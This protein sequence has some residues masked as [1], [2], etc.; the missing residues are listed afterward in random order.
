[1]YSPRLFTLLFQFLQGYIRH[2]H[3][4]SQFWIN[5]SCLFIPWN[6]PPYWASILHQSGAKKQNLTT[7]R[8][9]VSMPIYI[10]THAQVVRLVLSKTRKDYPRDHP[11]PRRFIARSVLRKTSSH[12]GHF[13]YTEA[14]Q[15]CLK[16]AEPKVYFIVCEHIFGVFEGQHWVASWAQ[17]GNLASSNLMEF[18]PKWR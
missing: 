13:S 3:D 1:M 5:N 8:Q 18:S 11:R 4:I 7:H 16:M 12:F 15:F 14:T 10:P 9:L 17:A 6:V 2:I